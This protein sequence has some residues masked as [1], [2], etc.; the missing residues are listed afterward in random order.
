MEGKISNVEA[1]GGTCLSLMQMECAA[2]M[3]K[4]GQT[5]FANHLHKKMKMGLTAE[6]STGPRVS[7]LFLQLVVDRS[8]LPVCWEGLFPHRSSQARELCLPFTSPGLPV[9]LTTSGALCFP[10][11]E[12]EVLSSSFGSPHSKYKY[13]IQSCTGPRTQGFSQSSPTTAKLPNLKEVDVRYTE[14]W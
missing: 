2:F 1:E 13:S 12:E 11:Q 6:L 4:V 10:S 14:A 9:I 5:C 7:R 8:T 3:A